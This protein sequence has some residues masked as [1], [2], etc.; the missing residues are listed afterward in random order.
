VD[1]LGPPVNVEGLSAVS[2][3]ASTRMMRLL[4]QPGR[5]ADDLRRSARGSRGAF[6]PL[7]DFDFQGPNMLAPAVCGAGADPD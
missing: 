6:S 7:L 3:P 5:G 1:E 4:T 2:A